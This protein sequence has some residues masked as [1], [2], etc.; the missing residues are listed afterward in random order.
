MIHTC[1]KDE[2]ETKAERFY[3]EDDKVIIPNQNLPQPRG[4]LESYSMDLDEFKN[5]LAS[6][7][8]VTYQSVCHRIE[9]AAIHLLPFR[10]SASFRKFVRLENGFCYAEYS[11]RTPVF[12]SVIVILYYNGRKMTFFYPVRGNPVNNITNS[13]ILGTEDD[14]CWLYEQ[15]HYGEARPKGPIALC[16]KDFG[17]IFISHKII[18]EDIRSRIEIYPREH[19]QDKQH[20]KFELPPPVLNVHPGTFSVIESLDS[21]GD[22]DIFI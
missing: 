4:G 9:T 19:F 18:E 21:D 17:R 2:N 8:D 15:L 1:Q 5:L 6:E 22:E 14:I 7:Q 16:A 13:P 3:V 20:E 11:M 12:P 10:T